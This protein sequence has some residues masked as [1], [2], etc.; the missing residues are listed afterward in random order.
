[1]INKIITKNIETIRA[2]CESHYVE[3]LFVFGSACTDKFNEKS[4]V[5]FLVTFKKNTEL[6]KYADNF[7]DMSFKLEDLF[8]RDVDLIETSC[9]KNPYFIEEVNKSKV[10]VYEN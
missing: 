2:L 3:N 4:D 1:M 5:D 6:A 8:E 10:L 7:F 9:L